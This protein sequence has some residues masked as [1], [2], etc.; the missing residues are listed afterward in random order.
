MQRLDPDLVSTVPTTSFALPA[1]DTADIEY[2]ISVND[3][4]ALARQLSPIVQRLSQL[5][6]STEEH[7]VL[8]DSLT[9]FN[10]A[11]QRAGSPQARL[12]A[13]RDAL[14]SMHRGLSE[15]RYAEVVTAIELLISH[16][17]LTLPQQG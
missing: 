11:L 17:V 15:A 8:E 10:D 5:T 7:A 9:V 14:R 4:M 3:N 6:L 16:E 2:L 13:Y 12:S 1:R